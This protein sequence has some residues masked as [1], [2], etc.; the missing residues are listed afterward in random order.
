MLKIIMITLAIL[1]SNV[2]SIEVSK[3]VFNDDHIKSL[4]IVLTIKNECE[5]DARAVELFFS[6]KSNGWV[7]SGPIWLKTGSKYL[8]TSTGNLAFSN[9]IIDL[10]NDGVCE[11]IA[12]H[13]TMK[14]DG[15]GSA[16]G[17]VS[18]SLIY[19]MIDGSFTQIGNIE[20]RSTYL[21]HKYGE[22]YQIVTLYPKSNDMVA[23]DNMIRIYKLSGNSYT[24][25]IDTSLSSEL[26]KEFREI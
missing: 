16:I 13:P 8:D 2:M 24:K 23:L 14:K 19:K 4:N 1:S 26:E 25:L 11:V 18:R 10:D 5:I 3:I 20:G 9:S 6:N 21:A 22:A 15:D 7:G 12:Y 17:I